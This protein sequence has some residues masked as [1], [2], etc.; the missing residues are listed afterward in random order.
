MLAVAVEQGAFCAPA[1]SA[2]F[3]F[4]VSGGFGGFGGGGLKHGLIF[5]PGTITENKLNFLK[6]I[7][8]MAQ[9]RE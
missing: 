1:R 5:L 6:N 4:G 9:N 7:L 2:D 3:D 8:D